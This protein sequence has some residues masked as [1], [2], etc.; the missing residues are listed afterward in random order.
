VQAAAG[1]VDADGDGDGFEEAGADEA[2]G[3]A[4]EVEQIART[5][6]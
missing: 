4:V 3:A 2:D 6:P 5:E 1:A